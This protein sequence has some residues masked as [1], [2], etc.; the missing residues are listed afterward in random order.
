MRAVTS[1]EIGIES[2]EREA[3]ADT[4]RSGRVL[5]VDNRPAS[6]ER[7][8]AMLAEGQCCRSRSERGAVP[9]RRR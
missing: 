3:V 5:F 9:C 4:G 1:R 7:I 2:P 8:A 6:H